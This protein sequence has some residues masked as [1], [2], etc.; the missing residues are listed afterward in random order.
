MI[1]VAIVSILAA[2]ALPAYTSYIA[3]ARR[4]DARTQ[5]L[6]AAQFMQK[7]YASNDRYDQDRAATA[8]IDAMPA[9][10]KQSPAD[11]TALYTL[12]IPLGAAPLTSAS[13]FTL[14]M[15]PVVGGS[16]EPDECGGFTLDSL[17]IRGLW[18]NAAQS[19]NT[20]LRDKCWR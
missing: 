13:S 3:R 11:G 10:L 7:F 17:G 12:S 1:T 15:V 4:A 20:A 2:V 16:M 5:L 8:I 6:Q 19:T 18:I 9:N 14:R